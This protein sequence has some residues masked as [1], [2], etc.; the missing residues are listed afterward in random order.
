MEKIVFISFITSVIVAS[1]TGVL[2]TIGMKMVKNS[3][4]LIRGFGNLIV[5]AILLIAIAAGFYIFV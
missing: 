1:V 2:L 5:V 3:N 4:S